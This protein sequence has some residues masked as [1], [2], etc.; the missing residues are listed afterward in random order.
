M[1]GMPTQTVLILPF[2]ETCMTR[3]PWTIKLFAR[4]K[5]LKQTKAFLSNQR[6]LDG[7]FSVRL[8]SEGCAGIR[9]LSW[10]HA[11]DRQ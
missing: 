4:L 7:P 6:L 8:A 5:V 10:A 3:Q 9:I 2:R 1:I 11:E